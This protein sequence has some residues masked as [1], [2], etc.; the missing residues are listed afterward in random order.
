[1]LSKP[2]QLRNTAPKAVRVRQEETVD[3]VLGGHRELRN[4]DAR[5]VPKVR[6]QSCEGSLSPPMPSLLPLH[7]PLAE[8][9]GDRPCIRDHEDDA[10]ARNAEGLAGNETELLIAEVLE[11]AAAGHNVEGSVSEGKRLRHVRLAVAAFESQRG[12]ELLAESEVGYG[13]VQQRCI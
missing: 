10:F 7:V 6:P 13:P 9:V 2:Q 4:L 11:D 1:M 8:P 3:G 12:E 5:V